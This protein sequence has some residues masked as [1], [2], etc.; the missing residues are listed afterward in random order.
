[1]DNRSTGEPR[2]RTDRRTFLKLTGTG[3]LTVGLAGCIGT[4]DDGGNGNGGT[5]NGGESPDSVLIGQPASLT[6]QWDFL[7]PAVSQSTD[8]AMAEVNEAGGPLGA[9]FQIERRDTAVE[10]Q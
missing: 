4:E 8:L 7:Q 1:M 3:A 10:P 2:D 9:D 6:G 5:T